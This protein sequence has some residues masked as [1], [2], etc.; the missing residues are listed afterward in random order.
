MTG[1]SNRYTGVNT[2]NG[3][4]AWVW[5]GTANTQV[6]L[7][8]GANT[9]SSGYQSSMLQFQNEAGIVAGISRRDSGVNTE[10]GQDAGILILLL[11]SRVP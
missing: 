10:N 6:G 2:I 1:Y 7:T 11:A 3:Q 4:D 9:G 5:N 8:S